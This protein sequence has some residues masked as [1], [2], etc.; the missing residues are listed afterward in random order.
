MSKSDT[1]SLIRVDN[2][3]KLELENLKIETWWITIT[4]MSDK[5]KHLL[6]HYKHYKNN[7]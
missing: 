1:T 2:D 4:N 5:I 7:N 6:W 3:L